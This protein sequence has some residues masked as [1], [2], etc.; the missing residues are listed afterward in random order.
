[1]AFITYYTPRP[2]EVPSNS[3]LRNVARVF[4]SQ[5]DA[6]AGG[7]ADGET[8]WNGAVSDD[9]KPGWWLVIGA[10]PEAGNV[11]EA[12]PAGTLSA[13]TVAKRAAARQ[14]HR[15]LV[16]WSAA[17]A[18]EGIAHAA[19]VVAVGHDFLYQAHR[20]TYLV[21][22]KT[23]PAYTTAQLQQW[24]ALMARGAAD[25]TSPFTFFRRMEAGSIAAPNGPCAWVDFGGAAGA[26]RR[27]NLAQAQAR[28]RAATA[29]GGLGL[30]AAGT[31]LPAD[32]LAADGSWIDSLT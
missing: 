15:A 25:V 17:L 32:G 12:L 30:D 6:T 18:A 8:A 29:Q 9:V 7:A 19:S 23:G 16:G 26:A 28:S 20:A 11:S 4:A 2:A 10:T 21:F 22:H 24:A 31:G 14:V 13:D 27:V 3:A 1:M 5:A